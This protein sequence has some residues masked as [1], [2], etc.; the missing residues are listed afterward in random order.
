MKPPSKLYLIGTSTGRAVGIQEATRSISGAM[1][2]VRYTYRDDENERGEVTLVA[3]LDFR[4]R[5]AQLLYL[6]VPG[7]GKGRVV[8]TSQNRP[9]KNHRA[10]ELFATGFGWDALDDEG[11]SDRIAMLMDSFQNEAMNV[12]LFYQ[13]ILE[14]VQPKAA[15][16]RRSRPRPIAARPKAGCALALASLFLIL[17]FLC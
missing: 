13:F 3:G 16:E 1:E 15:P 7:P 6:H 11:K 10:F 17:L 12:S 2:S 5:T 4:D 9:P 8:V 14:G